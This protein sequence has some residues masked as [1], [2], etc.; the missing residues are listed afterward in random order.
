MIALAGCDL[1]VGTHHLD[2][3]TSLCGPYGKPELV[4]FAP[5]LVG[6]SDLS[7]AADGVHGL[8]FATYNNT[9]GPTPV[10]FDGATWI[11]DSARFAAGV[12]ATQKLGGGHIGVT[13]DAMFGWIDHRQQPIPAIYEYDYTS[14]WSQIVPDVADSSTN[15]VFSG[16]EVESDAGGGAKTRYLVEIF[17]LFGGGP[18]HKIEILAAPPEV[19]NVFKPS[20]FVDPLN[21]DGAIDIVA[22]A[23]TGDHKILVYA[24][25][26]LGTTETHFFETQLVHNTFQV[27]TTMTSLYLAGKTDDQPWLNPDC[28]T[29]WFRRDGVS[30]VAHKM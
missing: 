23:L 22:G 20:G 4:A 25:S 5:E 21:G 13:G 26:N 17:E 15:N 18:P 29:M 24:A 6:A 27:G 7:V 28:T 16:Q 30:W 19:M 1:V 12:L 3:V 9:M 14:T 10:V 11:P 8:V 2:P